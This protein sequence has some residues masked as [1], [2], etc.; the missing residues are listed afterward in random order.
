MSDAHKV[1][2]FDF[3]HFKL[4]IKGPK[5]PFFNIWKEKS[6]PRARHKKPIQNRAVHKRLAHVDRGRRLLG[7]KQQHRQTGGMPTQSVSD[8]NPD[9]D[10]GH[11]TQQLSSCSMLSSRLLGIHPFQFVAFSFG[12]ALLRLWKTKLAGRCTLGSIYLAIL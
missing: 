12:S 8:K 2:Y 5:L 10:V 11:S 4:A 7:A 6:A 3:S 1:N 9:F